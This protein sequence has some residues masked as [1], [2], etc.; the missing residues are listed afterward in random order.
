[1]AL[2][3]RIG[4]IC[5]LLVC[6]F[7][8][9]AT[10]EAYV[11]W[12]NLGSS[13][14]GTTIG[15]VALNGVNTK[16]NSF[17]DGAA[18]PCGVA[19]NDTHVFWINSNNGDIGRANLDGSG[20]DPDFT[21]NAFGN[22]CG[23]AVDENY[24]YWAAG[25]SDEAIGRAEITGA[26]P[27]PDWID[28]TG[29][30]GTCGVA[31]NGT[32]V[33]WGQ[34]NARIGR[35]DLNGDNPDTDFIDVGGSPC[36]VAANATHL[37][38]G[39]GNGVG[40]ANLD[41]T[42]PEA[43]F[44]ALSTYA[45]GVALDATYVYFGVGGGGGTRVGRA[46]L[47]GSD[48]NSNFVTGVEGPCGVAVD[49]RGPESPPPPPPPDE[50]P[51]PGPP[52]PP[53]PPPPPGFQ[54]DCTN[55][56]TLL[57]SCQDPSGAPGVCSVAIGVYSS[58]QRPNQPPVTCT[59]IPK[60]CRPTQPGVTTACGSFGTALPECNVST[61]EIPGLCQ[62][63]GLGT[64]SAPVCGAEM[65]PVTVCPPP[66]GNVIPACSFPTNVSTPTL[67]GSGRPR[68]VVAQARGRTVRVTIGCPRVNAVRGRCRGRVVVDSLRTSL[69]NALAAHARVTAGVYEWF[70]P[71]G[72]PYAVPFRTAAAAAA[73]QA[74]GG[75]QKP[76]RVDVEAVVRA[77]GRDDRLTRAY[78]DALRRSVN[79]Y[80]VLADQR[81]PAA[82]STRVAAAQV[83]RVT[84]T[85]KRFRLRAGRRRATIRVRLT[86]AAVGRLVRDA[87]RRPRVPVRVLVVFDAEPQP[88]VRFVDVALRVRR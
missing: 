42:L 71:E 48:P 20:I 46:G 22:G 38:W 27:D 10:A 21:T 59:G 74:L 15:R 11:Y 80:L 58:C 32:H 7:A 33:F 75:T 36:G 29:S 39:G 31:V 2:R 49:A 88:V 8:H 3:R 76:R 4:M 17:I 16:T 19:V 1:M 86:P 78:A 87:G 60:I 52:P 37:Y 62:P 67:P 85:S 69:L 9:A 23:I 61:R 51:P 73:T 34:D 70:V 44:I 66:S 41:G 26:N 25:G 54:P 43:Q 30:T 79:E 47:D 64:P 6:A 53:P 28:A 40:R 5:A 50:P 83:T 65:D 72:R 18:G 57:V 84:A 82:G 63:Q 13:F 81:S 14:T 68:A 24:I 77:L 45:C 12:A 35:A 56:T 55:A